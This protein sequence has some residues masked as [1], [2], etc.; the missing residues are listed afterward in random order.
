MRSRLKP[1]AQARSLRSTWELVWL[2][3]ATTIQ[4]KRKQNTTRPNRQ[5]S[6]ATARAEA[7]DSHIASSMRRSLRR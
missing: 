6:T 4:P 2:P 1:R 7:P 5:T 3:T